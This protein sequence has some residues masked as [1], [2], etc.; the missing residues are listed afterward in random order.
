M[1]VGIHFD[2]L[3]VAPPMTAHSHVRDNKE[4]ASENGFANVD[5]H[6]LRHPKYHNIYALGDVAD[7]PTGKTASAVFS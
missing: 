5:I 1:E 7:L 4:L 6:T 2:L 3:H